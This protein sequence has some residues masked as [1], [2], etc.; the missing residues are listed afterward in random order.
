MRSKRPRTSSQKYKI[1]GSNALYKPQTNHYFGRKTS[2]QNKSNQKCKHVK[3][4]RIM[5]VTTRRSLLMLAT[6]LVNF[7]DR[8]SKGLED[9]MR[10]I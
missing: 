9:I 7:K 10:K 6:K 5:N 3:M 8:G 4:S 2:T 1:R